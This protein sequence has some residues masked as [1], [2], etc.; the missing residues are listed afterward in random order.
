M[1]HR[2]CAIIPTYNHHHALPKIVGRLA[3][4]GFFVFLIDDGSDPPTRRAVEKVAHDHANV[5]LLRLPVNRGKGAAVAEGFRLALDQGYT[6]ALQ[7]DADGQHDLSVL[8]LMRSKAEES[9]NSV[10]SGVPR[11]DKS[12]PFARRF[13]R[14]I[15]TFWVRIE[16]RSLRISDA[17]CGLRIYPL[18]AIA[19]VMQ[20]VRLRQRMDFDI[21]I[22]VQ[23]FWQRVPFIEVPVTVTYPPEN[24]SNFRMWRDNYQ[25]S[26]THAALV[27]L[28]LFSSPKHRDPLHWS[29]IKERGAKAGI[30]LLAAI[31]RL[32][33]R[34]VGLIAASL[35]VLFFLATG[36]EQRRASLAFF[37]RVFVRL[38]RADNPTILTS[39]RHFLTFSGKI[40]DSLGSWIGALPPNSI[41]LGNQDEADD[42]HRDPRGALIIISHLG[43]N[44]VSRIMLQGSRKRR[45]TVLVH[46]RNA[47]NYNVLAE[48]FA[49]RVGIDYLQ[50]SDIGP[51]T[52]I[53]LDTRIKAGEWIAIAGDRTPITKSDYTVRVPFLGSPAPF[54]KGPYLLAHLL[55]CPIY[56]MFCLRE[57]NRHKIYLE[58]FADSIL[59]P[60]STRDE[61]IRTYAAQYAGRLEAFALKDPFQWYNFFDFWAD[62]E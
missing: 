61:A 46:T 39:F 30:V 55:K 31:Y 28:S 14:L 20:K 22:L 6:H 12:A 48:K 15:T 42:I 25:I 49:S 41:R 32:F 40:L 27:W 35:P 44:D 3:E 29:D 45:L 26:R 4:Q 56:L 43:N 5:F 51:D 1:N 17:M 9:P 57:N 52:A 18:P 37:Q 59:L 60:R 34:R 54:P 8:P 10:I 38:N 53:F 50:V 13:G 21:D 23:L 16:T 19:N 62:E 33:G 58:R 24:T 11:F 2:F 47:E 7:I 36:R